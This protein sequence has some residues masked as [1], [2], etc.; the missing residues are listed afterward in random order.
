VVK[1]K[2]AKAIADV[3]VIIDKWRQAEKESEFKVE[4]LLSAL[5]GN[6]VPTKRKRAAK[7]K[8]AKA[9]RRRSAKR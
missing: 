4:K 7:R 8:T 9:R 5:D 1:T 3:F 2:A 6:S